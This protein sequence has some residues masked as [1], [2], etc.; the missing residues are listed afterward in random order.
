MI[1]IDTNLLIYAHRSG[2]PEHVDARRAIES[3]L[4]APGGC[5]VATPSVAEFF[6]IVTHPTA[7]GNPS[8]P[9]VAAEFLQSLRE[10]GVDDLTPGPGF[11]ARLARMA[12]NLGVTGA[13]VFDLQIGLCALDGGATSVWTHDGGFVKIPG[14]SVHDPLTAA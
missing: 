5:G 13:R 3:A 12:A 7:T 1:A 14:L 4:N 11:A 9:D 2:T 10:S 6:S 8:P